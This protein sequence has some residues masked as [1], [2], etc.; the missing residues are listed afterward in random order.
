MPSKNYH[1]RKIIIPHI[2]VWQYMTHARGATARLSGSARDKNSGGENQTVW[3]RC[4]NCVVFYFIFFIFEKY[5]PVRRPTTESTCLSR[6][7]TREDQRPPKK[8]G[9]PR[10][11]LSTQSREQ[12]ATALRIHLRKGLCLYTHTHTQCV[13]LMDMREEGTLHT[14]THLVWK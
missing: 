14:G 6:R 5:P 7:A 1:L 8:E 10:R 11:K 13:F 3:R 2:W 9:D 4:R 12:P